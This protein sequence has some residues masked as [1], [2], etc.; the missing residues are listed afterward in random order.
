MFL[1]V[2]VILTFGLALILNSCASGTSQVILAKFG[3]QNITV[4]DFENAYVNNVGSYE[5]AKNDS[6][7]KLRNFLDLYVN[8]QMKLRDAYVRGYD[9]DPVLQKELTDYKKQVGISYILEKQLVEPAI[10]Q[11]YER[12][13]WEYRVSLLIIK[14]E[15][16][17][18][19]FA[20][21]LANNLLDSI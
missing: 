2:A 19:I 12:R 15:K 6:L 7:Y 13:K 1:R 9:K 20:E 3:D 11:L 16:N 14:Q 5:I 8:F 21:K 4:K 17:S 10:H 18:D